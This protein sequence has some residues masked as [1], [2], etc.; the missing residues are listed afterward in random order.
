M[1]GTMFVRRPQGVGCLIDEAAAAR[2]SVQITRYTARFSS[3]TEK[4]CL[5]GNEIWSA[6]LPT[7]IRFCQQFFCSTTYL[8]YL[9]CSRYGFTMS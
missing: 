8:F 6:G 2:T 1:C 7:M 9:I 5:H 3:S 4:F